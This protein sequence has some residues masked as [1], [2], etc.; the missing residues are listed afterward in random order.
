MSELNVFVSSTCYDL[1]LLR[2]QLRS[3]IKEMGYNPIMSDYEDILYDP[4]AHTHTSCVDEVGNC[5]ILILII[6]SRFGGK[7]S[8]E[9]LNKI[10]FDELKS[11][12]ESESVDLLKKKENLSITQ[13]EVLTAIENSIPVYTFI[14]KRVW[15]D[16]LLYEKNKKSDIIEK[17]VFPSIEKQETAKYIFNFINFIRLRTKN[18]NIFTF[19]KGQ[20]IEEI[21]KK[22]WANYFQRLLREQR[23]TES[24]RKRLDVLSERFEDLKMAILSSINDDDQRDI[25]RG[26]I[27]FRRLFDFLLSFRTIDL[28]YIKS[29]KDTWDEMLRKV[30][31]SRIVTSVPINMNYFDYPRS[32]RIRSFFIMDNG[33]FYE[34]RLTMEAINSISLDWNAFVS[35]GEKSREIIGDALSEISRPGFILHYIKKPFDEVYPPHRDIESNDEDCSDITLSR[36]EEN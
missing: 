20:D 26:T 32:N 8:L 34:S 33:L 24:E 25:A 11:E 12:S 18:N 10:N 19:E 1:S 13:L 29:T 15:H 14:E 28:T 27:R 31:V 30:G 9:S 17:I 6:G 2:S 7:A 3:F 5:D 35:M 22:Q 4:R 16:H 36:N 21:L 23:F